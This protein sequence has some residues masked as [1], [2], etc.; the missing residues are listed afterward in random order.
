MD[1]YLT[2]LYFLDLNENGFL[3]EDEPSTL[4]DENG[5]YSILASNADL[6]KFPIVVQAIAGSTVDLDEPD[7]EISNSYNLSAPPGKTIISP[8][9]TLVHAKMNEGLTLADARDS[10]A[11]DLSIDSSLDIMGDYVDAKTSNNH[12]AEIHNIASALAE[13]LSEIETLTPEASFSDKLSSLQSKMNSDIKPML[14]SIKSAANP[15]AAKKLAGGGEGW[16]QWSGDYGNKRYSKLTQIHTENV[17][18]LELKW[19]YETGRGG[20]PMI[21]WYF[22]PL[23]IRDKM[24]IPDPGVFSQDEMGVIAINAKNGSELWKRTVKLS[25]VKRCSIFN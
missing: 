21:S 22:N 1:I 6:N 18:E 17:D 3:D 15:S 7:V 10:V 20:Q 25:T 12:Y 2:Q 4:T 24:Y 9:T 11:E 13:V 16:F 19:K 23:V 14:S 8:I 5:G